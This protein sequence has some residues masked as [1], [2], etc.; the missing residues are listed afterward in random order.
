MG[1][2]LY[3]RGQFAAAARALG[4]LAG[5]SD[6]LASMARFYSGMSSRAVGLEALAAGDFAQAEASLRAAAAQLGSQAKVGSHL[7]RIYARTGRLQDCLRRLERIWQRRPDAGA[8]RRLAQAQWQAGQRHAAMLTLSEGI[9]RMG[10]E[11]SLRLQMG[12]FLCAEDRHGQAIEHF[13]A[14]AH[15][16]GDDADAHYY[17]GMAYAA[18][19]DPVKA[20]RSL[21]RALELSPWNT[22]WAWQLALAARAAQQAGVQVIINLP[23]PAAPSAV[24]SHA[25]GLVE[26]VAREPDVLSA[27]LDLPPHEDDAEVLGELLGVV[28]AALAR[29][30][31]WADLHLYCC[32]LLGRLGHA[33][34]ALESAQAALSINPRYVAAHLAAG[35]LLAELGQKAQA[36]AHLQRAIALGADWPDVHCLAGEMAAAS[37]PQRAR[38]HLQRA[39]ELKHGYT[40]AADALRAIA[41]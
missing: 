35:G 20:A 19:G 23:Q 41:A 37:S 40:R 6:A 39:L 2:M 18:S 13:R 26:Y 5:G 28:Q 30:P 33:Q 7:A 21:Q 8:A 16:R 3:R 15:A 11:P 34:E 27:M 29:R 32:R 38:R 1:V 4:P 12:L 14:C 31:R 36:L 10:A 9:R 17:L 25:T 24:G 22:V